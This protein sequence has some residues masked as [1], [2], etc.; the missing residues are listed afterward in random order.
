MSTQETPPRPEP[1]LP[2]TQRGFVV[3]LDPPLIPAGYRPPDGRR[4]Q[5]DMA[6]VRKV[7]RDI[8]KKDHP[9]TVRQVFYQLVVRS[10]VEKTETEYG[11]T[12]SRLIVEM[13]LEGEIDWSWI[14]DETRRMREYQTYDSVADAITDT[15]NTYRRNAMR[16]SPVYIEVWVE[17]ESLAGLIWEDAAGVYDVPVLA[18]KGF[19]SLT[20]IHETVRAIE[21]NEKNGKPS[22]IYQFGD[23]DPSGVKIFDSMVERVTELCEARDVT[24]PTFERVALTPEQIRRF[25]LPSRPT[26]KDKNPHAQGW[27]KNQNSTELDALPAHELRRMVREVIERH[28]TPQFLET[29]RAAEQSEKLNL[30]Q[31]AREWGGDVDEDEDEDSDDEE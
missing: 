28:I 29:L 3:V 2:P 8:L 31:L 17:K 25:S 21:A 18:S 9:Q 4:T 19:S 13:R 11:K 24:P 22:F 1:L 27:K 14:V 6:I 7:I 30:K 10:V 20:Q 23:Y 26:K 15:A 5:A 16:E 12:A